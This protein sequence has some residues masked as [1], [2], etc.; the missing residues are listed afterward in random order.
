M[1]L[2]VFL[3]VCLCVSV[4]D[5]HDVCLDD[6]TIKDWGHTNNTFQAHS[7]RCLVVQVMF[8]PLMT[9]KMTSVGCKVGQILKLPYLHQYFSYSIDQKLKTLEIIMAILLVYSTLGI[10]SGK[11][12]CCDLKMVAILRILKYYTQ[13]QFD[14]RYEKI[15][16]I[17]PEKYFSWWRCHR[18]RHRV[19][20]TL[21]P[22]KW[23]KNIFH[24]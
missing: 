6:L 9:S 4:Y 23:N 14:L 16:Q 19:A 21:V 7:C 3:F 1:C 18:W 20:S 17:M 22:Y 2:F 5:C 24:N 8:H 12:V 13:L 11:N 15:A 10:T